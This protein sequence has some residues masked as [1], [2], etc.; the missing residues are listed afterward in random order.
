MMTNCQQTYKLC[1]NIIYYKST[2]TNIQTF[3]TIFR[4]FNEARTYSSAP[5]IYCL[6]PTTE[7]DLVMSVCSEDQ[8]TK[9]LYI[10]VNIKFNPED[11]SDKLPRNIG[12]QLK[13]C[14]AS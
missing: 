12:K 4:K 11:G 9:V 13:D 6:L 5:G 14:M 3:A 7:L 8:H 10:Y 1:E 2:I